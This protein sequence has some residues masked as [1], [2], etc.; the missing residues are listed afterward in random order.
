MQDLFGLDQR[1]S[2]AK[3]AT[4]ADLW[5]QNIVCMVFLAVDLSAVNVQDGVIL[6]KMVL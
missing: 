4:A 6:R 2:T 3:L 5:I 1:K